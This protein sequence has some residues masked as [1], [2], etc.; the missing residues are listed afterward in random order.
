MYGSEISRQ[1]AACEIFRFKGDT[2]VLVVARLCLPAG[3]HRLPARRARRLLLFPKS[4][5][6][7]S[8]RRN[9]ASYFLGALMIRSSV[10]SLAARYFRGT[11]LKNRAASPSSQKPHG[12]LGEKG[13]IAISPFSSNLRIV[14]LAR[15]LL[16]QL[17]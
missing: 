11:L 17:F 14:F 1:A 16:F 5:A 6:G 7:Y 10:F 3:I 4:S 9:A 8:S 2:A 15:F 13:K 12:K